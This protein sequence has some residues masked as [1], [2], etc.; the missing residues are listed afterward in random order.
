MGSSG[1]SR[2]ALGSSLASDARSC[3]GICHCL[4]KPSRLGVERFEN[5]R[6]TLTTN[7]KMGTSCR[8]FK[9][10][11]CGNTRI[12]RE[13]LCRTGKSTSQRHSKALLKGIAQWRPEFDW[14]PILLLW[15]S[16]GSSP[17]GRRDGIRHRKHSNLD[18]R[19]QSNDCLYCHI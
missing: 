16:K 14:F 18:R 3:R 12:P 7:S 10:R 17:H 9:R 2:V 19:L 13:R 8:C 1:N 5:G 11:Q 15:S 4:R 6:R